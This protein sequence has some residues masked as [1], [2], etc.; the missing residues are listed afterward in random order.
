MTDA[1]LAQELY[2]ITSERNRVRGGDY[3]GD[4][5]GQLRELR[6]VAPVHRGSVAD[7]L[8]A[9]YRDELGDAEAPHYCALSWDACN[10]AFR[11]NDVFSSAIY[12]SRDGVGLQA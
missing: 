1:P 11:D 9:P 4:F 5:Y 2:D 7:L 12:R 10:D 8:G 6:K 3:A